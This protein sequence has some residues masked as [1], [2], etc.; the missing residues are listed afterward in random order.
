MIQNLFL[1]LDANNTILSFYGWWKFSVCF[2]YNFVIVV[3][4]ITI[5]GRTQV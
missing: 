2:S 4:R 3:L 1:Q 5:L